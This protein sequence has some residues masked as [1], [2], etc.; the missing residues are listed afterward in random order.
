MLPRQIHCNA[1]GVR[2]ADRREGAGQEG[3]AGGEGPQEG[4]Q[5]RGVR[6]ASAQHAR[7]ARGEAGG[8]VQEVCR[9]RGRQPQVA[10]DSEAGGEAHGRAAAR[11]GAAADGAQQ[12]RADAQPPGESVSR[13]AAPEQ[14]REGREPAEDPRGGG[15]AQGGVRQVP[16]H[17]RRDHRAHAAE[18]REELQAARGQ[19]GDDQEVQ[20]PVRAVRDEGAASGEDV[21]A[22]AAG[23]PAGRCEAGQGTAGDSCGE[24]DLATGEAATHDGAAEVPGGVPGAPG[25]GGQSPLAG[26]PLHRQVRRVPGRPHAQQRGVRG[27]QGRDGQ[28]VAEGGQ[29]AEGGA[30]VEGPLREE[31]AGAAGDGRGQ[32]AAGRG[33]GADGAQAAAAAEAVSHAAGGAHGAALPAQGLRAEGAASGRS[34]EPHVGAA[35]CVRPADGVLGRPAAGAGEHLGPGGV[36]VQGPGEGSPGGGGGRPSAA[37]GRLLRLCGRQVQVLQQEGGAREGGLRRQPDGGSVGQGNA[38]RNC[39][40]GSSY[41]CTRNDGKRVGAV[42]WGP[43]HGC[44]AGR[45][46]RREFS[47]GAPPGSFVVRARPGGRRGTGRGGS[48]SCRPAAPALRTRDRRPA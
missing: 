12:G 34:R 4:R 6:P 37:E 39:R 1:G 24:G 23:V 10:A 13:A 31:S 11:E 45:E 21:E 22:D 20:E 35:E 19:P 18:Q 47:D 16:E 43:W 28:D 40:T 15:E 41:R 14:G 36:P 33:A 38:R 27:L 3:L 30:D 8:H 29:D 5:G 26:R 42:V 7:L 44:F 25:H 2:P 46:Y 48:P 32:A 17:A 9:G